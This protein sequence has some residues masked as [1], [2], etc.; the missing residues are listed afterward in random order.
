MGTV[1]PLDDHA[2]EALDEYVS[3]TA[4]MDEASQ[5]R[6]KARATLIE[7]FM[8]HDADTGTV[9]ERPLVRLLTFDRTDL[10]VT[11]LKRQAPYMYRRFERV[12]TVRQLRML[13]GGTS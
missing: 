10:N 1:I 2:R 5:R 4:V 9:D 8:A 3:A 11:E 7:F 6:D 12:T 13:A